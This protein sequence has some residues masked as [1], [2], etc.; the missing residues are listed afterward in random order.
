MFQSMNGQVAEEKVSELKE[1]LVRIRTNIFAKKYIMLY[2]ISF[3]LG[4]ISIT[5]DLSIFSISLLAACFSNSVP[6]VGIFFFSIIGNA[7][8]FGASGVVS[9]ILMALLMIMSFYIIKPKYNEDDKNEKLKVSKNIFLA[10]FIVQISRAAMII[11]TVYD[12]LFSI[13]FAILCII[14]YKI[15]VNALTILEDIKEKR[16]F[17]IEEVIGAS[18]LLAIAI[19]SFVDVAILGFSIRNVLSILIVLILGWKNG[20]LVGTTAGVTIGVTMGIITGGEP[21][22]IAAYAIS[23]MIAGLLNKFGRIGVVL[24]F[25]MGNIVLAYASNG[26]KVEIIYLKEILIASIALFVI[27]KK[28][29]IDIEEFGISNQMLP[30]G[31]NRGIASNEETVEKL[32][33][34]S[35]TLNK[36]IT[37]F[38]NNNSKKEIKDQRNMQN[39]MIE[40]LNALDPYKRN[41]F[42]DDVTKIESQIATKIYERLTDKQKVQKSDIVEVYKECG[43]YIVG[44]TDSTME[45]HLKKDLEQILSIINESY[46]VVKTN[47]VCDKKIQESKANLKVQLEGVSE[48][49]STIADDLETKAKQD[50]KYVKEV[51]AIVGILKEKEIL[52]KE[53]VISKEDRFLIDISLEQYAKSEV[54]AEVLTSV[55]GEKIVAND[56]VG[57]GKRLVFISEDKYVMAFAEA[58]ESKY[59]EEQSGDSI[60]KA[61]LRDGKYLIAI[62]DGM[63]TGHEASESSKSALELLEKLLSTGFDKKN[64]INLI[65]TSLINVNDEM[66]STL[67]IAI[68]DLYIGK[69][70]YIKR[71]AC[72]TYMKRNDKV[73]II[74]SNSLP[75]GIV[76]NK[77]ESLEVFE[78]EIKEGEIMMM[79]TDGVLEANVEYTNKELWV[80]YLLEDIETTNT[81]KIADLVKNEAID[82]NYGKAK[83]D[84]SIIVCKFLSKDV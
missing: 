22:I 28:I 60:L 62:S 51:S 26:Y 20:I 23:G 54:I 19:S 16:A 38:D 46:N 53:I 2:V 69:I 61:R 9:Y 34:V 81:K 83:D 27:P 67:D 18:M 72:Q 82:N 21:I 66:F 29:K 7:V 37:I 33:N 44:L 45:S 59:G 10:T 68:I 52:A 42:Y 43:T 13:T 49:I 48:V 84:V 15:F 14:F 77:N 57:K 1:K 25:I 3:M 74:K 4:T 64:S 5:E 30:V 6:L 47:I 36:M 41:I 24:G 11:L 39:F 35:D 55:L 78:R 70:E 56:E 71:G 12:V 63:G 76:G 40:L 8:N 79:C 73:Q 65:T 17:S 58:T 75:L 31:M 50:I 32:N 80:K